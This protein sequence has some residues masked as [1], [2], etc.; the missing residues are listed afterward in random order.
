MKDVDEFP[1]NV[2]KRYRNKTNI[3]ENMAT[4]FQTTLKPILIMCKCLGLLDISYTLKSTG[5]T[6]HVQKTDSTYHSVLEITR[7]FVLLIFTYA[8]RKKGLTYIN[9]FRIFKFWVFISLARV[10]QLKMIK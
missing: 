6:V 1:F 5:S 9:I 7:M 3:V 8:M 2:P 4:V 10:S